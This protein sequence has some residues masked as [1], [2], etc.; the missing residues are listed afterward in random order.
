[1]KPGPVVAFLV[2]LCA[3]G[4]GAKAFVTNLTP[5]LKFA[6]AKKL[7]RTVQV[8]GKLDKSQKPTYE[9]GYLHFTLVEENTNETMP[10]RF[11]GAKPSAFDQAISISAIGEFKEGEFSAEKLLVKCPSKYQG[12]EPEEKGYEAK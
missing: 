5:Y 1:M 4:F 7:G 6:E 9:G 2:I 8:M 11:K 10:V 3:F 12:K